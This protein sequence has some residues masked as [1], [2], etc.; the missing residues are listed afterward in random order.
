[1]KGNDSRYLAK[2]EYQKHN[3]LQL[4]VVL[5]QFHT[6]SDNLMASNKHPD[7]EQY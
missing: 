3:V 5:P 4:S 7:H 6:A 1:M 2:E